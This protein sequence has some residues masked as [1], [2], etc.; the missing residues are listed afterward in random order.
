V[1]MR[2]PSNVHVLSLPE[3]LVIMYIPA[4]TSNY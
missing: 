2:K 1:Y 4:L 3:H